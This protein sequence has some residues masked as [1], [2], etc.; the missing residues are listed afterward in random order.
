MQQSAILNLLSQAAILIRPS[1]QIVTLNTA[2]SQLLTDSNFFSIVHGKFKAASM[3]HTRALCESIQVAQGAILGRSA[4]CIVRQG[5][6][7]LSVACTCPERPNEILILISDPLRTLPADEHI[8]TQMFDF[9]RAEAAVAAHILKG[10]D[11]AEI[12]RQLALSTHTVRNHLKQLFNK[13]NTKA[14]CELLH[15]LLRSPAGLGRLRLGFKLSPTAIRENG[16]RKT[17]TAHDVA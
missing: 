12:A 2:A 16:R 6:P 7:P 8:I 10:N 13:T 1:G 17:I 9:T 4:F 14:H 3:V 15:T 11:V 5:L